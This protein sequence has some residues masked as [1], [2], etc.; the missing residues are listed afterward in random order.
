MAYMKVYQLSQEL[1]PSDR[2]KRPKNHHN[3]LIER[4]PSVVLM[5]IVCKIY[6]KHSKN[7]EVYQ[8]PKIARNS[9]ESSLSDTRFQNFLRQKER[10]GVGVDPN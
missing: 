1:L 9:Q 2:K 7:S 8:L 10:Q 3:N 6:H 4:P 5:A